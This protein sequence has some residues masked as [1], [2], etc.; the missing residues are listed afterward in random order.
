MQLS[1]GDVSHLGSHD[2]ALL[3]T[4]RQRYSRGGLTRTL[5][6]CSPRTISR[7]LTSLY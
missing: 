3:A 4:E 2:V 1:V 6:R 7:H 5:I